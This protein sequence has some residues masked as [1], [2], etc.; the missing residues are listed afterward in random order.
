MKME[1]LERLEVHLWINELFNLSDI[2]YAPSSDL[3][4]AYKLY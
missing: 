1:R 2:S 4:H 3:M